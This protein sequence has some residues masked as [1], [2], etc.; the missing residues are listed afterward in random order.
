MS[1]Y[2]RILVGQFTPESVGHFAA[3]LVGQFKSEWVGQYA[4]NLHHKLPKKQRGTSLDQREVQLIPKLLLLFLLRS[5]LFR[6][7]QLLS[8]GRIHIF[9]SI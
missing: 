8:N 2:T 4:R 1:K 9:Q 7:D 3:E 6:C 5:Y